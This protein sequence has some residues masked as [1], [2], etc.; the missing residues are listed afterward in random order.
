MH[1][2]RLDVTIWRN[3]R[4]R[5]EAATRTGAIA[6]IRSHLLIQYFFQDRRIEIAATERDGN[7]FAR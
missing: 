5:S 4:D 2:Q 6:T 7:P 1:M 3:W